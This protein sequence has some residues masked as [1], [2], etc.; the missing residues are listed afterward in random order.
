[1]G[2]LPMIDHGEADDKI[3]AVLETDNMWTDVADIAELPPVLVDRIHHYFSTYKLVPGE[4][5]KI[6]IGKAY[7]RERAEKVVSAAMLDYLDHYGN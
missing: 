5:V 7:G 2:G 3:I 1:L 6:H 4:E